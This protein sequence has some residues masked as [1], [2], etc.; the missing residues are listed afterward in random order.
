MDKGFKGIEYRK[1]MPVGKDVSPA[2]EHQRLI[3]SDI[4]KGVVPVELP[5]L[6]LLDDK[7]NPVAE[8][9]IYK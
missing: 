5:C 4:I 2:G 6:I 7:G 3:F 9:F 1:S 8:F